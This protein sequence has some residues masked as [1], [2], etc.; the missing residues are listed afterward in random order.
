MYP[1]HEL[2]PPISLK[3]I[4]DSENRIYQVFE[5]LSSLLN[6]TRNGEFS[7]KLA[8]D[9]LEQFVLHYPNPFTIENPQTDVNGL[10][11]PIPNNDQSDNECKESTDFQEIKKHSELPELGNVAVDK[12]EMN[13][14]GSA[15]SLK[16]LESLN[17]PHLPNSNSAAHFDSKQDSPQKF[18]LDCSNCNNLES[19]DSQPLQNTPY[20]SKENYDSSFEALEHDPNNDVVDK[21][22]NHSDGM[23]GLGL[24]N[25]LENTVSSKNCEEKNKP[26]KEIQTENSSTVEFVGPIKEDIPMSKVAETAGLE[27]SSDAADNTDDSSLEEE[28]DL[29]VG[30]SPTSKER[31]K[32]RFSETIEIKSFGK[33]SPDTKLTSSTG[34]ISLD[35]YTEPIKDASE[36][37]SLAKPT[38]DTKFPGINYRVEAEKLEP[39]SPPKKPVVH[40]PTLRSHP[41]QTIGKFQSSVFYDTMLEREPVVSSPMQIF[42]GSSNKHPSQQRAF[43]KGKLVAPA[44]QTANFPMNTNL[45]LNKQPSVGRSGLKRSLSNSSKPPAAFQKGHAKTSSA[46]LQFRNATNSF[47]HSGL[48]PAYNYVL[49]PPKNSTK[50][51]AKAPPPPIPSTSNCNAPKIKLS[52][53]TN[54]TSNSPPSDSS[55]ISSPTTNNPSR[56]LKP[57][58]NGASPVAVL[59]AKKNWVHITPSSALF[60]LPSSST[61][62][63][64]S[65]KKKIARPKSQGQE[66]QTPGKIQCSTQINDEKPLQIKTEKEGRDTEIGKANSSTGSPARE[67]LTDDSNE[68]ELTNSDIKEFETS[69]DDSLGGTPAAKTLDKTKLAGSPTLGSKV[70]KTT[71][72]SSLPKLNGI[73]TAQK[74]NDNEPISNVPNG[75]IDGNNTTVDTISVEN[76]PLF[77]VETTDT[78][79]NIHK[80]SSME[81]RNDEN[82]ALERVDDNPHKPNENKE[83]ENSVKADES[84]KKD[85][86]DPEMAFSPD[87]QPQE[88]E[89]KKSND[90][91]KKTESENKKETCDVSVGKLQS[92]E[93][94]Q[95]VEQ[96]LVY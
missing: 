42:K 73:D 44:N 88:L 9:K 63:P 31:R 7:T 10:V 67:E 32:V 87:D 8:L 93:N 16:Y 41:S 77:V 52:L 11:L 75:K 43:V 15:K 30:N 46:D 89:K 3:S 95:K 38:K 66:A 24:N 60:Q 5:N 70:P 23:K 28:K 35:S 64:I 6:H 4:N 79:E 40:V 34:M 25:G 20:G 21:E 2:Q 29:C 83:V 49:L 74:D 61:A 76:P 50:G 48:S 84:K 85:T 71:Q 55:P 18:G 54:P 56:L 47:I 62:L 39:G 51:T 86:E 90:G 53:R 58:S 82:L 94:H 80:E 13:N 78:A 27:A 26:K 65:P 19:C 1:A 92:L 81:K 17:K 57:S 12:L 68:T 36:S 91:E 72:D 45:Q 69:L 14:Y 59:A 96:T 33:Q 22:Q 37:S